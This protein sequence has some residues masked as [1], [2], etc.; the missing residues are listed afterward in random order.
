MFHILILV[1]IIPKNDY[2]FALIPLL[3][4]RKNQKQESNFQQVGG[5]IVT[6][7]IFIFCL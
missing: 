2:E 3:S 5:L 1:I 4:F 6:K 7:N